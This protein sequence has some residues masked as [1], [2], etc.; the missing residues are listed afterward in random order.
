MELVSFTLL[1]N[2]NHRRWSFWGCLESLW[3]KKSSICST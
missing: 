3:F 2:R 1:I